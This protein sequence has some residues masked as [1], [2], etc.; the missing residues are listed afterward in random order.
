MFYIHLIGNTFLCVCEAD[1]SIPWYLILSYSLKKF[2]KSASPQIRLILPD[3]LS[4][5]KPNDHIKYFQP[6][7]CTSMLLTKDFFSSNNSECEPP[8]DSMLCVWW[9][10]W[11]HKG[12][13]VRAAREEA[14]WSPAACL[15]CN[16][17]AK[18][19]GLDELEQRDESA[20]I[21]KLNKS[22]HRLGVWPSILPVHVP[23]TCRVV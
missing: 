22:S 7:Y 11:N 21:D 19:A 23:T 12:R 5:M 17:C 4:E 2:R 6:I 9:V 15:F 13:W 14:P 3:P 20:G 10:C 18:I 1:I 8:T 16:V